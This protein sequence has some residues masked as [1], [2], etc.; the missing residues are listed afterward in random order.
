MSIKKFENKILE[1]IDSTN[2]TVHVLN[3]FIGLAFLKIFSSSKIK[4][5]TRKLKN[6]PEFKAT[7]DAMKYHTKEAI[8]AIQDHEEKYGEDPTLNRLLRSLK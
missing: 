6:D 7:V 1:Q 5:A 4:K 2:S 3:E 8:K